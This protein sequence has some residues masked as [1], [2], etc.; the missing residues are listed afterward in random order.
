MSPLTFLTTYRKFCGRVIAYY[1]AILLRQW[2]LGYRSIAHENAVVGCYIAI[3]KWCNRLLS[4]RDREPRDFGRT[5]GRMKA[6]PFRGN[7]SARDPRVCGQGAPLDNRKYHE[8]ASEMATTTQILYFY[9]MRM[10]VARYSI[11]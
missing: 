3:T 4:S 5:L 1:R 2:R 7:G 10:S 6:I 8:C 11:D 9:T